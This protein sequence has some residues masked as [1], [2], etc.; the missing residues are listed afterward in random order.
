MDGFDATIDT[1]QPFFTAQLGAGAA[2]LGLL[3]VGLSLNLWVL[4]VEINR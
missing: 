3:F 2:L 4:L 1:W